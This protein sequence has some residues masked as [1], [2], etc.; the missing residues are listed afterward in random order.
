MPLIESLSTAL[1][2]WL[3]TLRREP[4]FMAAAILTLALG[5]GATTAIFSVVNGVLI[6]PLPY[7]AA[8]ELLSVSHFAPGMGFAESVGMSPS[9]LFTYRE[10]GRVFQSIGG[11]SPDAA[12]VTGLAEPERTRTLLITFGTLQVLNVPP[13]LGRWLSHED[14]TPGAHE[15]VL[16]SYGYWQRRFGGERDA[17]SR[18]ITVDGRLR[19]IV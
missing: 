13:L 5:I 16:L 18:A 17:I 4:M 1:R 10:E 3:R 14:D 8:G 11:W 15:V 7:P 2:Y 9:M 12:T 6:K 19:Q